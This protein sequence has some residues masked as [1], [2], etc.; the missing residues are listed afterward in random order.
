MKMECAL[1]FIRSVNYTFTDFVLLLYSQFYILL[2]ILSSTGVSL[3]TLEVAFSMEHVLTF[4]AIKD[5]YGRIS[6]ESRYYFY[7]A[8]R[9]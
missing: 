2:C 1:K 9:L 3:S 5:I 7:S 4:K 6:R 8:S